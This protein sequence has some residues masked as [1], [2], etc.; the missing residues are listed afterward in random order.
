MALI[1]CNT[2]E[3]VLRNVGASVRYF[4][5]TKFIDHRREVSN[6]QNYQS[7]PNKRKT[8]TL[9]DLNKAY[10]A[11]TKKAQKTTRENIP[12]MMKNHLEARKKIVRELLEEQGSRELSDRDLEKLTT[13]YYDYGRKTRNGIVIA[14][15]CFLF[16]WYSTITLSEDEIWAQS[17]EVMTCYKSASENV[18]NSNIANPQ[19]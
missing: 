9:A 12:D 11:K 5:R 1:R 18:Q 2:R 7:N 13:D 4:I 8:I 6:T 17:E 14:L 19:T 3:L 15:S 16:G 10:E